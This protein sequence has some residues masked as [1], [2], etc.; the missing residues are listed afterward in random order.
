VGRKHGPAP[1]LE[2]RADVGV[3]RRFYQSVF[4]PDMS[5]NSH[6]CLRIP[7]VNVTGKEAL[8]H[9]FTAQ[10]RQSVSIRVFDH[11]AEVLAAVLEWRAA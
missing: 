8:P 3:G 10:R 7:P 4:V 2:F 9:D 1:R 5:E 6:G 11:I